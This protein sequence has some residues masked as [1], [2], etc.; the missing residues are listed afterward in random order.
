VAFAVGKLLSD[1]VPTMANWS[2]PVLFL[3]GAV[4]TTL[5]TELPGIGWIFGFASIV[6]GLGGTLWLMY[7]RRHVA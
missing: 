5:V 3:V 4:L 1:Y 7:S 2:W 6:Y